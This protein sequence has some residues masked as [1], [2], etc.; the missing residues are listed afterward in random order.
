MEHT[1]AAKAERDR[2]LSSSEASQARRNEL[3]PALRRL[4]PWSC[5]YGSQ[6]RRMRSRVTFLVVV[7]MVVAC[8]GEEAD[9]NKAQ[10]TDAVAALVE[11]VERYPESEHVETA[12]RRIQ[13]LE[14]QGARDENTIRAYLRFAT[15]YPQN[16]HVDQANRAVEEIAWKTASDQDTVSAYDTFLTQYPQSELAP[17]AKAK[18][19]SL[20]TVGELAPMIVYSSFEAEGTLDFS[21]KTD[22]S[23]T[24]TRFSGSYETTGAKSLPQET[25]SGIPLALVSG[26][27]HS[28][29]GHVYFPAPETKFTLFSNT[30]GEGKTAKNQDNRYVWVWS[31]KIKTEGHLEFDIDENSSFEID[32]PEGES[33]TFLLTPEGYEYVAGVGSV[34]TPNGKTYAFGNP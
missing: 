27:K 31:G 15:N 18:L 23:Q 28:F 19:K 26:V 9:W 30:N 12:E 1:H 13:A 22:G 3:K 10:E 7:A 21:G 33:L 20:L 5:D 32:V 4:H 6:P 25:G 17:D 34:K 8:G 11:F 29:A 24:K 2:I 16:E 14:W